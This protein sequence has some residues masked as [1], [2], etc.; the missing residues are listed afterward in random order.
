VLSTL[1]VYLY[2]VI[3]NNA[4]SQSAALTLDLYVLMNG[5]DGRISI[6]ANQQPKV[7]GSCY[8]WL[9]DHGFGCDDGY[10]FH[11]FAA[12]LYPIILFLLSIV[13]SWLGDSGVKGRRMRSQDTDN[14]P[15]FMSS[16]IALSLLLLLAVA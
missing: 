9:F 3:S 6:V 2:K 8:T 11:A 1:L 12:I 15:I 16:S 13:Y 4:D 10:L 5:S 7:I 14:L